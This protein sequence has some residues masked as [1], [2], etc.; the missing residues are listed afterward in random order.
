MCCPVGFYK[1][2]YK[3][4]ENDIK[5]R[6][7]SNLRDIYYGF[8]D[9]NKLSESTFSKSFTCLTNEQ[10]IKFLYSYLLGKDL[11]NT[12]DKYHNDY[13]HE[14]FKSFLFYNHCCYLP[15]E[16]YGRKTNADYYGNYIKFIENGGKDPVNGVKGL[17]HLFRLPYVMF[18]SDFTFDAFHAISNLCY[19]VILNWKGER[20][21]LIDYHKQTNTHFNLFFH[22]EDEKKCFGL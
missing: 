4:T 3:I 20:N 1:K 11:N 10:D 8:M 14:E 22:S 19:N 7:V 17:H 12:W 15:E 21:Y 13:N 9:Y 18:E 16:K 6:Q 2:D 5:R